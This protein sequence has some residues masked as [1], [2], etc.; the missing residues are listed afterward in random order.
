LPVDPGPSLK[1]HSMTH[2]AHPRRA[3]L[4]AL[5]LLSFVTAAL[6]SMT[7][8]SNTRGLLGHPEERLVHVG[9]GLEEVF[10]PL[11]IIASTPLL[12]LSVLIGAALLADQPTVV[13]LKWPV[14]RRLRRNAL[15]AETRAYANGWLFGLLV[16]LALI[17]GLANSGKLEGAIGKLARIIEDVGG[18]LAYL[19]VAGRALGFTGGLPE[20]ATVAS[21]TPF[22]ST[23]LVLTVTAAAA[24]SAMIVVRF[25]L[26][27][28]IWLNPVPFIDA[29]FEGCKA[30]FSLGLLAIYVINPLVAAIIGALL[31]VPC[32]LLLPWA[33]RLLGFAHGIVLRPTLAR[34]VPSLRP[35]LVEAPLARKATGGDVSLACHAHAVRVRGLRK[36]QSVAILRCGNRIALHS[37]GWKERERELRAPG[38][39]VLLGRTLVWL[40]L[41]V[42]SGDGQVLDRI[43]LPRSMALQFDQLRIL[44]DARDAGD[45][46]TMKILRA[47]GKWFCPDVG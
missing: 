21:S 40:E 4:A 6:S 35:R 8:A 33:L 11:P 5:V 29:I 46:G 28:I 38:E 15:I 19:F 47:A 9:R 1:V 16:V 36:R 31:L 32:L 45:L 3:V 42:V 12:G 7:S 44:L 14:V 22:D 27:V 2:L 13:N 43:A 34:I 39:H 30:I 10:G 24:L 23:A 18:G 37:R 25:A 20:S 41:R 26:D 17:T